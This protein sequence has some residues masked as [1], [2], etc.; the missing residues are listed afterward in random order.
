MFLKKR[1]EIF[2]SIISSSDQ[3]LRK[4]GS[5]M[6]SVKF[7]T[8]SIYGGLGI[9]S[10]GLKVDRKLGKPSILGFVSRVLQVQM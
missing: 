5:H 1:K 2:E 10:E 4:K 8:L 7:V 6:A 3:K 9:I